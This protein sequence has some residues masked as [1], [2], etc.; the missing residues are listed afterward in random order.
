MIAE[1]IDREQPMPALTL[2]EVADFLARFRG[3]KITKAR[4]HQIEKE[5]LAKLRRLHGG[6]LSKLLADE[7]S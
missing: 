6:E 7:S 2:T 1:S 3:E 4:V 5:A